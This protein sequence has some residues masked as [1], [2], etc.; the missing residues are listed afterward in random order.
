[1]FQFFCVHDLL[2]YLIIVQVIGNRLF[3]ATN[4][5]VYEC[6]SKKNPLQRWGLQNVAMNCSPLFLTRYIWASINSDDR[7]NPK[8]WDGIRPFV[9][10]VCLL[11]KSFLKLCVSYTKNTRAR[12]CLLGEIV[13][14]QL[15]NFKV[16]LFH[17][18]IPCQSFQTAEGYKKKIV[19]TT[20][21][22]TSFP[23]YSHQHTST[24]ICIRC[25]LSRSSS[26]TL[27]FKVW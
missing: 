18:I 26:Q 10:F 2:W 15:P 7:C 14:N 23:L 27:S 4:A 3:D 24:C 19:N 25:L 8:N 6:W 13:C 22:N 21:L 11:L 1:M 9:C 12:D 5:K 20:K 17:E 16:L